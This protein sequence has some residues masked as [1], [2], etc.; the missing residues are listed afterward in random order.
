MAVDGNQVGV[1][2]DGAEEGGDLAL[3]CSGADGWRDWV[4]C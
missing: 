4:A 3:Y 2:R 1:E